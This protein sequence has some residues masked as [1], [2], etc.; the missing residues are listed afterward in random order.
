MQIGVLAIQGDIR[1]HVNSVERLGHNPLLVRDPKRL[2]ELDGLIMPGGESTTMTIL[3]KR[4]GLWDKLKS[5]I[6][7]GMPV[8]GTC[9]GLVLLSR[10]VT[11]Y[12]EQPTLGVLDVEVERNAYGSQTESFEARVHAPVFETEIS[13]FFIRAPII[14]SSSMKV[15]ILA[16]HEGKPVLVRQGNILASTFHPEL[17]DDS[18]VHQLF[19]KSISLRRQ[20]ANV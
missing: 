7:K 9:A 11:N 10:R 13:A 15:E 18:R 8:Y 16:K 1:E 20:G 2:D 17:T 5:L 12:P 6:E 3:M 19:L 14:R 4:F